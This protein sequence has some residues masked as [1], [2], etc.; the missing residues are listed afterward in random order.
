MNVHSDIFLKGVMM[1]TQKNWTLE[2]IPDQRGKTVIITGA[3]SGIGFEATRALAGRGAQVVMACRSLEKG[4]LAVN[5]IR[6]ENPMAQV[7]LSHLDLADLASV[8]DFS[9][10]FLETGDRLD[11]LINNAGVMAIPYGKTA[12][13]FEMQFGT[14]HLGHFVLTASLVEALKRTPGSRV[15][16]VSSYAHYLGR[17]NFDDLNSEK[18]YQKWLAYGQSKLAN[19]IFGYELQRRIARN[20]D[21]PISVVVHPGYAATNLQHS[22]WFFRALNPIMAQ[23]QEM[24]ALPTLYAATEPNIRGGEYIG[25]DGF[26]GQHGYPH[27][28]RSSRRSHDQETAKRLWQVSEGLTGI[29][30][31]L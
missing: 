16:T 10:R 2:K 5:Q 23:S 1:Q 27:V 31:D 28:A 24:G 3:N 21:N 30:F 6:S 25:P 13:G 7:E 26:F 29:Q 22:S 4:E 19:V 9:A 18:F 12:D 14:N 20:G 15:V 17:I 11:I 8:R